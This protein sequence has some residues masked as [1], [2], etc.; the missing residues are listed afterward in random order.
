MNLQTGVFKTE[1]AELGIACGACHA[2]GAEH[3]E[4]AQSPVTRYAWRL[5]R[6]VQTDIVNPSKLTSERSLMLCGHCHGQRM[7]EPESR[8]TS[9]I[10]KGDPFNAGE[11]LSVYYKP[12]THETKVNLGDDNFFSF[13]TR[14]WSNG[15][16]R[17]T[18]YEYQGVLRSK[19]FTHG[20]LNNRI[21]CLSC[22]S[23]H[24]GDPKGMI[25]EENRTD[26]ACLKCHQEFSDKQALVNHTKHSFDSTGSRCYNCHLPRVVYGVMSI[27]PTHD[28]TVPE[29]QLTVAQSVP[30]ACNQCHLDKS[31]NWTIAEAKRLWPAKYAQTQTSNDE[32]FNQPEGVRAM[33]AGDAVMR[34]VAVE[35]MSGGGPAKPDPKWS[36]PFLIEAFNDDYPIVRFFAANGLASFF[37]SLQ[38]PDYLA[39]QSARQRQ[40]DQWKSLFDEAARRHAAELAESLRKRRINVDIEVGE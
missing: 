3:I 26:V 11:D 22:H 33:F 2:Q 37:A 39:N 31:A 32:Q 20:D 13:A 27:H 5:S 15:S 17:L 7:P 18:A 24:E 6:K 14:F 30:N 12:V 21:N 25:K 38:K 19:C 9:I 40:L 8:M 34:A 4:K 29:P 1:V 10:T 23:M 36:G 16:P 35:A 28:I